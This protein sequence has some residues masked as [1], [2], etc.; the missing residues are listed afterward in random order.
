[1]LKVWLVLGKPLQVGKT[2][3]KILADHAVDVHEHLIT[4]DKKGAGPRMTQLM[5]VVA[6]ASPCESMVNSAVLW[7]SNGLK[8]SSLMTIFDG[9]E[10]SRISMRPEPT[11]LLPS[12]A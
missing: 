8:K 5:L 1:M 4:L 9:D 7:A 12:H 11:F 3:L 2:D 10:A 6:P